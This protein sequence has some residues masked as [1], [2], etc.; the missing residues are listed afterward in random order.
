[1][2]K[3]RVY[4]TFDH[5][6]DIHDYD[7]TIETTDEGEK[8]T[9]FRSNEGI[10]ADDCRGEELF[11]LLDT[12]NGV[13]FPKKIYTKEV[14]YSQLAELFVVLSVINKTDRNPIYGGRVEEVIESTN[15]N[16]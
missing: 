14:D 9:L 15:F 16:I 12:G 4:N 11:S 13:I 10:W 6:G 1:M 7:V 5:D 3:F 8:I 2:R